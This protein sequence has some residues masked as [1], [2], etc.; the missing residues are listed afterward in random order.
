M[1]L[2]P[3]QMAV[4]ETEYQLITEALKKTKF[5][6]GQAAKLLGIDRKTMY[7]KINKY[8]ASQL[9]KQEVA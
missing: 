9:S 6:K 7:N 8:E 1:K 4:L 5:N 3:Y 2:T